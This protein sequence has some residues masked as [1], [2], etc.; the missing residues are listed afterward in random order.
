MEKL[1]ALKPEQV[2]KKMGAMR[3]KRTNH[4]H[5]WQQIGDYIL[6]L[7]GDVT[8]TTTPGEAKYNNI[9]DSTA[10]SSAELFAGTLVATM[11]PSTSYFFGL[12]TGISEIDNDDSV[13]R[14]YQQCTRI[15]HQTL[16]E[17]NFYTEVH[18]MFLSWLGYG[19][20]P[21]AMEEDPDTVATFNTL[22][23]KE[24][25]VRQN[26]KK[27]I[28]DT[29]RDWQ[30]VNASDLVEQFGLENVGE[31]VTAAYKAG[32]DEKFDVIHAIYPANSVPGKEKGQGQFRF[33]SQFVLVAEKINLEVKGFYERPIFYPRW[34][35]VPGDDYGRGCGEKALPETK[36]ANLM[37]EITM[38]GAQKTIDPP[39]QGPD[40]GYIYPLITRPAGMNYYRA[41]GNPNDRVTP[42]FNDT[43]VDFGF[44]AIDRTVIKIREAFYVDQLK[45]RD[46]PQMTALEVSERTEQGLRFL[47]PMFG[48]LN[49]EFLDPMITRLYG[50]HERKGLLPPLP[51]IL[52]NRKINIVF[53]SSMALSQRLSELQNIQRTMAAITPFASADPSILQNI[54]PD[55]SFKYIA[56]LCQFPQDMVRS[57]EELDSLRKSL[58]EQQD[59]A[60]DRAA[61]QTDVDNASKL[62]GTTAKLQQ[63]NA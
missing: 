58:Q 59:A 29:Y 46:G 15:M 38:K 37:T 27:V 17:S 52:K 22:P 26:A 12:S 28:V 43:R 13:L 7:A 20:G 41:G 45:L 51:E 48:R 50:I 47:S 1:K 31:K 33:I 25:F 35:V 2:I 11:T 63:G 53:T 55:G 10:P 6:P 32:K 8:T 21:M 23:I 18:A 30:K 3:A 42:I 5:I 57:K 16:H 14:Y 54:S 39:L 24:V 4:E 9:M 40:N 61:E 34:A 60:A 62:V 19:N 36:L 56:K 44:Q 49:S